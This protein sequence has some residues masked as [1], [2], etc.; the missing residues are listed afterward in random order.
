MTTAPL[1]EL[2]SIIENST[3][4]FLENPIGR[5]Y[6]L[7]RSII[8]G[9]LLL[10]LIFS[11]TDYLFD[12]DLFALHPSAGW[13]DDINFF[14]LFGFENLVL[15]KMLAI[16]MLALV[17]S[18]FFPRLTG[19]LH[20]WLAFSFNN[21]AS[22]VDGGDQVAAVLALLILP[23]TLFDGRT[24]HF[25]KSMEVN[26]ISSIVSNVFLRVLIPL[27]MS[28]IY[29]HAAIEKL[30]KVEE[31]RNGTAVYYFAQDPIFGASFMSELSGTYVV[32]LMTWG[33]IALE[34]L[35]GAALF[36]V[37]RHKSLLLILGIGFH[38]TI[39]MSFGLFSFMCSMVGGLFI[40]LLNP[41]KQYFDESDRIKIQNQ[42]LVHG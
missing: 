13:T 2:S 31:W 39:S 25:Y 16:A 7:A 18:G 15:A 37:Y 22:I 11:Q 23:V 5:V 6:G 27:Q 34:I 20:W 26:I 30:Y 9:G 42:E 41:A 12:K 1:Q 38:L 33:T 28:F 29:F 3:Q 21:A 4:F 40:Y 17:V 14:K 35:L 10:T 36:M 32:L 8:A 24:N 19:V